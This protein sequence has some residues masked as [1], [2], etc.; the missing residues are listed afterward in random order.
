VS[1]DSGPGA[2][3]AQA[4]LRAI[5]AEMGEVLESAR[6][7]LRETSPGSGAE[8]RSDLAA[9]RDEHALAIFQEILSVP[10]LGLPPGELFALAMDRLSRLL[11]ADRALLFVP[12]EG[13]GRLVPR[14]SRGFRREEL[15]ILSLDPSQGLIGRVFREKRV[16]TVD[17]AVALDPFVERFPVRQGIA[18]PVRTEGEVGGVLFAGRRTLGAPFSTT[19]VLLLLVIADRVGSA[20]VHQRLLERHGEHLAHLREVRALVDEQRPGRE[21]HD[22]LARVGEAACRVPGVRAALALAGSGPTAIT[23]AAGAGRL[24]SVGPEQIPP[25]DDLLAEGFAADRP[26]AIRDLQ[27]RATAR[28]GVLERDGLR[29]V[30]LVPLRSRGRVL[31]LLALADVEPREFSPEEVEMALTLAAVTAGALDSRRGLEDLRQALGEQAARQAGQ[32]EREKARVLTAFGAG[33]TRELSAVF[34]LLLGKSQ[35]MLARAPDESLRER[36]AALEEAAWRGT[37][38]TQRLL[39]LAEADRAADLSCDLGAIAREALAFARPRLGS[40]AAPAGGRIEMTADLP[41]T[42]PVAGSATALREAIVNIVLNAMEAM[43]A[44]GSVTVRLREVERGVELVVADSGPGIAPEVKPRIFDPFFTTRPGH[45]GLGLTVVQAVVLRAGGRVDVQSGPAG[46]TVILWLPAVAPS[47]ATRS[48]ALAVEPAPPSAPEPPPAPV[49]V[50]SVLVVEEEDGIRGAV[51]DAL[52]AAGHRV[53]AAVDATGALDR[54]ALGGIDVV[55]TDLALRDRSGLQ[56]AAAVKQ[57]SPGAA[58]VL[59][60]GWGRRLHEERVR[61]AGVDVMVVKPIEPERVRTAVA[62]ALRLHPP[63]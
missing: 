11:A 36:L 39:G 38:V 9:E 31:G 1:G 12:D 62:E 51:L 34:A 20:L 47:G 53:E 44:G 56:L 54:L 55:V 60:T 15:E 10:P 63:A 4:A 49:P 33:L 14:S 25:D 22:I 27:A 57:R 18:V 19:D 26:V 13:T 48:D 5:L 7:H 30:L 41:P 6:E 16:Q 3:G 23:A 24:R 40:G 32:A 43:P 61:G 52:A 29:A 21:P 42:S 59:L 28:P 8:G 35:L 58:V 37:D 50:G 2:V 45:L 46:T 17:E